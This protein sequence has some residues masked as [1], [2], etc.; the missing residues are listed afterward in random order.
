MANKKISVLDP[1][2]L[3]T[4]TELFAIVQP[5]DDPK[6]NRKITLDQIA[7]YVSSSISN[8]H[9]IQ[10]SG[11]ALPVQPNLN[12]TNGMVVVNDALNTASVVKL[13][14]TLIENTAVTGAFTLGFTGLTS[15]T[16]SEAGGTQ[17]A[18]NST[19]ITNTLNG[20]DTFVE[21]ADYSANYVARSY[22]AKGYADATYAPISGSTNYW[23]LNNG[24]TLTGANTI[25][26]T[27]TNTLK[28][29]FD[30][31][32]VT[33]TIGAG[34]W[35]ANTTAAAPANQQLSPS[36]VWEGQGWRTNATAESQS[37]KF[38]ADVLPVQGAA[39][40]TG[41]LRFKASINN[42]AFGNPIM[43]IWN[44]GRVSIGTSSP[45]SSTTLTVDRFSGANNF[46]VN[47]VT[48]GSTVWR[49]SS[50]GYVSHVSSN[51]TLIGST[52]FYTI[53]G[54]LSASSGSAQTTIYKAAP[55][56][57]YTGTASG[58]LIRGFAYEPSEGSLTGVQQLA[59]V[60][61]KGAFVMG[62][63]NVDASTTRVQIT[64]T[65]TGAG[66]SFLTQ[67]LSFNN[68]FGI[69][70]NGKV[71]L[72]T[73]PTNDD[74][75]T[76]Y[77]VWDSSGEIQYKNESAIGSG[78]YWKNTGSTTGIS[79]SLS[80]TA[81]FAGSWNKTATMTEDVAARPV[82]DAYTFLVDPASAPASTIDYHGIDYS[83]SAQGSNLNGNVNLYPFEITVGMDGTGTVGSLFNLFLNS[84][85]TTTGTVTNMTGLRLRARNNSTGTISNYYG[86]RFNDP[87]NAGT[88]T[89][90]YGIYIDSI[91][92][93]SNSWGLYVQVSNNYLKGLAIGNSTNSNYYNFVG[94]AIAANRNI[95]I[96]LLTSDDT[97]VTEAFGQTL[98]NKTIALGSN[99]IS[100]T[101]AQFDTAA[102]DGNFLWVGDI[103]GVTD[104][105]KGD[106]TVSGS[107]TTWTIDLNINK[108]WTGT[109]SFEDNDFRLFN[110]ANTFSYNFR[111]SALAANRDITLPLL[112]GA[113]T[114]VFNSFAATLTNKTLGTGTVFSVIPTI[115][116]GITFTFNP[117][118]TVSGLNVGAHT[119]DPSSPVNGDILY[120]STTNQLRARI[121]GSWVSLGA[122]G[123]GS[124][125][126]ANNEV[127][128]SD[129][130]GGFVASKLFFDE[131]TGNMTL[132]DSGL[133]GTERTITAEGSSSSINIGLNPKGNALIYLR[134]Y[135]FVH[136][137]LSV[138]DDISSE[139]KRVTIS[140][141]NVESIKVSGESSVFS[142]QAA[143][144]ISG[145]PVGSNLLM[146][147]GNG[148]NTGNTNGGH[149]YLK[150]GDKNGTGLDGN[151]GLL[152]SSVS[153]WQ[154]M[155]RGLFI[156]DALTAPTGNPSNGLFKWVDATEKVAK[157]RDEDGEIYNETTRDGTISVTFDSSVSAGEYIHVRVPYSGK[158]VS[159]DITTS[160]GASS[161]IVVDVRKG[162]YAST[163]P[164]G[165][166]VSIAGTEKPTLSSAAKN[167]DT[168]LST[169]TTAFSEDD[170][171][172]FYV[173]SV[174][175]LTG[176][177]HVTLKVLKNS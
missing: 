158:F 74:T 89:N 24:G 71:F 127:Q 159:W 15:F 4:G 147:A 78:S 148:F 162:T 83:L 154:S 48:S 39:N 168:S 2:V 91:T 135:S 54:T 174:S 86:V 69:Q 131:T 43:D 84:R 6:D 45:Q 60:A 22:I 68:R 122:G 62:K 40:P 31:L 29:K 161:S 124:S 50:L 156:A 114:F 113:D 97:M 27:T 138:S 164:L 57:N 13:G 133:T 46:L 63:S 53:S 47:F 88:F 173:D 146:S 153:N 116:D 98:T 26:G 51:A 10:N 67:D 171:I 85:N 119:A 120:N 30:S 12:F 33:Q 41:S 103:V 81:S 14:G 128:T 107:G 137:G 77:L 58:V 38:I 126:G 5:V 44:D 32:G 70:D 130:A 66:Y 11:S 28:F 142:I 108:A 111:T 117:N 65:G 163:F 143:A 96:P 152:T 121:N 95:T 20:T 136:D 52:D 170:Y 141:D 56:I 16:A 144:G 55:T 36:I 94:S 101:K 34:I 82:N 25:T 105:D 23:R 9:V 177:V 129:G 49:L 75:E 106:I 169:W 42:A 165:S 160:D 157:V 175:G 61:T 140:S 17:I 3:L 7:S 139:T 59:F 115:N 87:I 37:V 90:W 80:G 145:F 93:P 110:P 151:I 176:K 35:L 99:T 134:G 132:G 1:T 125:S 118:G 92:T 104:G 109:H 112:T 150:H 19:S 21:A 100:G 8:G 102:T 72:F 123:G 167:Q 166:G 149:I 76:K 172:A 79:A 73:E 18:I 155:E 64:G